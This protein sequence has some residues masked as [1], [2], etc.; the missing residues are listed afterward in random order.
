MGRKVNGFLNGQFIASFVQYFRLF[1]TLNS[2]KMFNGAVVV[3]QLVKWP[4]LTPV[5]RVLNPVI[6]KI[7]IEILVSTVLNRR[8]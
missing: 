6:I 1:D 5:V 3:S 2:N 4:F 7:Y 8:T